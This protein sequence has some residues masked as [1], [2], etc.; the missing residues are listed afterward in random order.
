M[1]T[2]ICPQVGEKSE[3]E[4]V[5]STSVGL[6]VLRRRRRRKKWKMCSKVIVMG[7]VRDMDQ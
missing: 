3:H 6:V 7:I 2:S 5:T 4:K 1:G